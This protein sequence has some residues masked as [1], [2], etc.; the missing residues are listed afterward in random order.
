MKLKNMS[1]IFVQH[2]KST[3]PTAPPT[4]DAARATAGKKRTRVAA[5]M[6]RQEQEGTE[7]ADDLAGNLLITT[8]KTLARA[9]TF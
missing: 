3:A 5:K 1:A 7:R 4:I 2:A 8:S 9:A 6:K